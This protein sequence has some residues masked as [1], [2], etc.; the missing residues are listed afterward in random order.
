[1]RSTWTPA[2]LSKT[3]LSRYA[4]FAYSFKTSIVRQADGAPESLV[5]RCVFHGP[6]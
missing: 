3:I 5:I 6:P 1:M 2:T 4:K